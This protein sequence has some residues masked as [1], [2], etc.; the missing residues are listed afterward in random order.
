MANSFNLTAQINLQGPK[1]LKKISSDIKKQLGNIQADVNL[2]LDP[3]SAKNIK[4]VTKALKNLSTVAKNTKGNLSA[5][6]KT[7]GSLGAGFNKINSVTSKIN[8]GIKNTGKNFKQSGKDVQVATTA[9]ED[10]GKQ[11]ALAVKR[12]AA[13][14]MV[15]SIVNQ[16]TGAL[17]DAVGEF[18]AFDRQLIRIQQVTNSSNNAIQSLSSEIGRLAKTFGVSSKELAEVSVTLSQAGLSATETRIALEALA[19][20]DLAPTFDN[21]KN[22][23]EGAI[24]ALR[25]FRL[26]TSELEGALGSINAVAGQ[27]AVE[28]SDIIT[29]IQRVGG[30]FS[31]ASKGV[32]EGTDALNEFVALFTSVRATTR[33][34]A[35][36]IDTGLRTIFT[37]IQR[38]S[39]IEMLKEFGVNLQDLEGQ[40]VGPFEAIKRLSEGLDG[41]SQRDVRF[42]G[43]VEELGGFRQI[44]KVIPLINE[45]ATAQEALAVAQRGQG[46][47]T[48]AA[49]QAQQALAVQLQKVREEFLGLIRDVGT[50]DT[51]QVLAKTTLAFASGLIKVAAAFKP[52]LPL[53]T[54]LTAAKGLKFLSEFGSGF[55]GALGGGPAKLA[56]G[57]SVPGTGSGDTVPAMLTPGEFVIR[58]SAVQA[59]GAGNLSKINKYGKGG[60]SKIRSKGAHDGDSWLVDYIPSGD[61]V[62]NKTTR[63][64]GIDAYELGKGMQ[65]EQNL[66]EIAT[67]MAD[68]YYTTRKMSGKSSLFKDLIQ[69]E[70]SVGRRP[71]HNIP[72]ALRREMLGAGVAMPAKKDNTA[73]GKTGK[74]PNK[75]QVQTLRANGYAKGGS[76]SDT[77]PALLTPGEFVIN[78]SSA[79]AFGYGNLKKINGY[80]K[81]GVVQHFENGGVADPITLSTSDTLEASKATSALN[82][83]ANASNKTSKSVRTSGSTFDKTKRRLVAFGARLDDRFSA[84]GGLTTGFGAAITVAAGYSEQLGESLDNLTGAAVST[85][86]AFK[87]A[88]GALQGLGSG[89]QS[90]ALAGAQIGGRRGAIIGAVS[91]GVTKAVQGAL[92]SYQQEIIRRE[93]AAELEARQDLEIAAEDFANALSPEDIRA[94]YRDQIDAGNSLIS[95]IQ[96]QEEA[97]DSWGTRIS[98]GA[99][100]FVSTLLNTLAI[101]NLARGGPGKG[102]SQGGVVYASGGQLINFKPKGTDT[103]PAMLTPGEF[104]VNAKSSKRHRGLLESINRKQG[105]VAYMNQGG[106]IFAMPYDEA[107]RQG[108]TH[109]EA[110]ASNRRYQQQTAPKIGSGQGYMGQ[111]SQ[112]YAQPLGL[113]PQTK[114]EGR[115]FNPETDTGFGSETIRNTGRAFMATGLAA[116]AG[117]GGLYGAGIGGT[118]TTVAG[119]LGQLGSVISR[120]VGKPIQELG[121]K[122]I[123]GGGKGKLPYDLPLP[124]GKGGGIGGFIGGLS[125]STKII[126]GLSLAASVATGVMTTFGAQEPAAEARI[127]Q[128]MALLEITN[129]HAQALSDNTDEILKESQARKVDG[130]DVKLDP[131]Q[132]LSRLNLGKEERDAAFLDLDSSASILGQTLADSGKS[133][134]AYKDAILR[135]KVEVQGFTGV[136]ADREFKRLKN[137]IANAS[138]EGQK[139][140][141]EINKQ[142]IRTEK[143]LTINLSTSRSVTKLNTELSKL[144]FIARNV[145][146]RFAIINAQLAENTRVSDAYSDAIKGQFNAMNSVS[147]VDEETLGNIR[148]S[149]RRQLRGSIDRV[150]GRAGVGGGAVRQLGGIAEAGKVFD[151]ISQM[152]PQ[153]LNDLRDTGR[154]SDV[155]DQEL[156]GVNISDE[157][158]QL[159]KTSLIDPTGK[160]AEEFKKRT[161]RAGTALEQVA[162]QEADAKQRVFEA[163]K[164]LATAILERIDLETS[165]AQ[166]SRS[167]RLDIREA[168][169]G[170]VSA[171]E[172]ASVAQIRERNQLAAIGRGGVRRQ[173]GQD[174]QAFAGNVLRTLSSKA[175]EGLTAVEQAALKTARSFLE[176]GASGEFLQ[177]KLDVL[178]ENSARLA[179]QQDTL[180]NAILDPQK[181]LKDLGRE[182]AISRGEIT[183]P[184]Q[185]LKGLATLEGR[186]GSTSPENFAGRTKELIAGGIAAAERTGQVGLAETLRRE[187]NRLLGENVAGQGEAGRGAVAV[188]RANE[189]LLKSNQEDVRNR[190]KNVADAIAAEQQ[191]GPAIVRL[192]NTFDS[193]S[194]RV[195]NIVNNLG[196]VEA[197]EVPPP[198]AGGGRAAAGGGRR[199]GAGGTGGSRG[200]GGAPERGPLNFFGSLDTSN[201]Q[202]ITVQSESTITHKVEGRITGESELIQLV[203]NRAVERS[204]DLVQAAVKKATRGGIILEIDTEADTRSRFG[205]R[206]QA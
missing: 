120:F 173:A 60:I 46:S 15:T 64:S 6:N 184:T 70:F 68:K 162:K 142:I 7:L 134:D 48:D 78:K 11:S 86:A 17:S 191:I 172:R 137:E 66:A 95:A 47:L 205:T 65:W 181:A 30:V 179:E 177:S 4:T 18:V 144:D 127:K 79:K 76:V 114:K 154:L 183:N 49:T 199:A 157:L 67:E 92:Q 61:E 139:L 87:T 23:T 51:F 105:G 200:V 107:I 133:V 27:F 108:K 35:E 106:S 186:R 38:G 73:T 197:E 36:T 109:S 129:K 63:A 55:G 187:Q 28:S 81:G 166:I 13:F 130:Q 201:A 39:T 93:E 168:A 160:A 43:I 141:E 97:A 118:G 16:F 3:K 111:L 72:D 104:V 124:G 136:K 175:P 198:P 148:G 128:D 14:T 5:L 9:I 163:E 89:V 135:S 112:F 169:G 150:A 194:K 182:A 25:Q 74:R 146:S 82:G 140:T 59:F 75:T 188:D 90:G 203:E 8:N 58:K 52:I 122:I 155:I 147:R 85:N 99:T 196:R 24:A 20:A 2:K 102:M 77:V 110:L 69:G 33:E 149:T 56:R 88:A 193:F 174:D 19:K 22:T 125:T 84:V 62:S 101:L 180:K 80:N 115:D 32:S 31:S 96:R 45:F 161:D 178:R 116:F 138:E 195:E 41:L 119:G 190:R 131:T 159:L 165:A 151:T 132:S 98:G 37:R 57:G 94:A 126:G 34:S 121:K 12:F 10:F 153:A 40:F 204:V 167:S 1:N 171:A 192:G 103:V 164:K 123:G 117:A 189:E 91:L 156:R 176:A 170:T 42:I 158:K 143:S 21:L 50:S 113:R 185:I 152:D 26:Q 29:A 206:Q 44:G 100:S 83:L 54:A 71:V 53:L 202:P 145:G